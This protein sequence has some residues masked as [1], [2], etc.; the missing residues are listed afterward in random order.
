MTAI[1]KTII[2]CT[3]V[4]IMLTV[5]L[6][7]SDC[8]ATQNT[9][10]KA[11]DNA[12][13]ISIGHI[14][15]IE[16]DS[17]GF[18]W[19]GGGNGLARFD[20]INVKLYK[21]SPSQAHSLSHNFILDL[22]TDKNG[23]LWIAT[24]GGGLNRYNSLTDDFT[25]FKH[26]PQNNTSINDNSVFVLMEG[27]NGTIWL[28]TEGGSLDSFN[29]NIPSFVHHNID[30][31][32]K[33]S[34]I[35]Q[36]TKLAE[37]ADGSVWIGT[38][39]QGLLNYFPQSGTTIHYKS[40]DTNPLSL[41]SNSI[42]ALFVDST[43]RLWI[44]TVGGGLNLFDK[45]TRKFTHF[46]HQINDPKS[47]GNNNI[48]SLEEDLQGNIWC[49]TDGGGLS[50]LEPISG[51]FSHQLHEPYQS[52]SLSTNKIFSIFKDRQNDF[53]LGH[54]PSGVSRQHRHGSAFENFHSIPHEEKSLSDNGVLA[55]LQDT[56]GYLWIGTENGLNHFD[57]K[58]K[59]FR[60]YLHEPHNSN[61]PPANAI[62]A[63]QFDEYHNIWLGTFGGGVS[64][65]E[66]A[67][68]K[69]THL[70]E[71][72]TQSQTL[73]DK[74]IWSLK[75]DSKK[76]LWI[77]HMS[78]VDIYNTESK[79]ITSHLHD[80][81]DDKSLT[82]GQVRTIYEDKN[83]AIWIG[84]TGGLNLYNAKTSNFKRYVHNRNDNNSISDNHIWQLYEDSSGTLW[85]AASIGGLNK[86]DRN[87]GKFS[88]YLNSNDLPDSFV[89]GLLDDDKGKL[90]LATN[91]GISSYDKSST[92]LKNYNEG[93]GLPGNVFNRPAVLRTQEGLLAFGST[94][95]FTL[96]DPTALYVDST[97]PKVIFTDFQ[98]FNQPVEI[99]IQG[100]P[101][102]TS[103]HTASEI[104][105]SHEQS[106][107]SVKFAGL[108]SRLPG[109]NIYEYKL[110]GFEDNW[111]TVDGQPIASY[112]NLDPGKY[113]L[114]ARSRN[115]DGH[116]SKNDASLRITVLPPLWQT[117]WAYGIYLLSAMFLMNYF[118]RQQ[119]RQ[120]LLER[121]LNLEL[122]E[123]V[124]ARTSELENKNAEIMSTQKQLISS[125]KMAS[126]GSMTAGIA[127]EINNPTNF[128]HA[129]V[130]M[131]QDEI[132]KIKN[133]LRELAGGDNAEPSVI[134]T[135]E[136]KFDNLIEMTCTAQEG[137][138]RIKSI[139]KD[140]S[141]YARL[142]GATLDKVKISKLLKST[143]HLVK[144]QFDHID[145]NINL[146]TDPYLQ[147]Y[148]SKLNQVFMNTIVNACQAIDSRQN[149]ESNSTT[150]GQVNITS[151]LIG[152]KYVV[153]IKDNGCGMSQSTLEHIFEPFFTTKEV[154][155]GSG[156][157]MA[158][159][160]SIIEEHDAEVN[161]ASTLGKGTQI[162]ISFPGD[163]II[164][165]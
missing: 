151:E 61:S 157:G 39:N 31:S 28:G 52:L 54:F 9:R 96:F 124:L 142:D 69:F 102:A 59:N 162:S 109:H 92:Q 11:I 56:D 137:T 24:W 85:V 149:S 32:S 161:V 86:L 148:P 165:T 63:L 138:K 99:G 4:L 118:I 159:T 156:L 155:K 62:I 7:H 145:F 90:W 75:L 48:T 95:G 120:V 34:S 10:F 6:V 60:R 18:I 1:H 78:G 47:I 12:D 111:N 43:E 108:N 15:A 135:I 93:H 45:K 21:H 103:I 49:G 91:N 125:A 106:I 130:Y 50:I 67:S 77:G 116:M 23:N 163:K 70:N 19:F 41:S 22:L 158:I 123:I 152:A 132:I 146:V 82:K 87:T 119:R 2:H 128:T 101:L 127:H 97:A 136:N 113:T 13:L 16:Q 121:K 160:Y 55:F 71:I 76:N 8:N 42:H 98:L 72:L 40:D 105:L 66:P 51:N 112:T 140:L 147:C 114:V 30:T 29:G 94:N 131:M 44:G 115:T 133:F 154:G 53:W 37:D 129:A 65:F 88:N 122:E 73:T 144:T 3:T 81:N 134:E 80:P 126:L 153:H 141:T 89:S 14:Y 107:F 117:W 143:L 164:S 84:T 83:G 139:V 36:I 64:Y 79:Q 110:E 57:K 35:N 46:T 20:G 150:V 58:T 74:R 33:S 38:E 17:Q 100:S 68:K 5:F 27:K 25:H 26:D 104:V